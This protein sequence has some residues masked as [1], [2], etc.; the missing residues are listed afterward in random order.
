[1]LGTHKYSVARPGCSAMTARDRLL[2]DP[3]RR[4]RRARPVPFQPSTTVAAVPAQNVSA[5][6]QHKNNRLSP[7]EQQHQVR[8]IAQTFQWHYLSDVS[9]LTERRL[10]V[11]VIKP[12]AS[13]K[14]YAGFARQISLDSQGNVTIVPFTQAPAIQ[15][16]NLSR[17]LLALSIVGLVLVL[18]LLIAI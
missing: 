3:A 8:Q 2:A 4:R 7:R 9:Y 16:S 18:T 10:A 11:A 17:W 12:I 14:N 6:T 15:A 1:M 13:Q 5:P